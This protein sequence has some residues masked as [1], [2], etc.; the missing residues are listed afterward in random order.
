MRWDPHS[1][2][3]I[4]EE[5]GVVEFKDIKEGVTV[6][7]E[8]DKATGV[9]RH[10]DHGAQGRPAPAD[11]RRGR[12]GPRGQV[13]DYLPERANLQVLHGQKASR[14]HAAR[15]DAAGSVADAGH[16]RGSAAR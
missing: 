10:D 9:V 2:P 3:L 14:R 13:P 8:L 1:V 5:A 4:T 6:R 7:K 15:Q 12:E 11:D 16:H